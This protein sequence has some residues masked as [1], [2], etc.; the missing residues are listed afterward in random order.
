[1]SPP[2]ADL[3]ARALAHG[4]ACAFGELVR[5]YQS[6]VRGFLRRM[7]RGDWHWADDLAQETFVKAWR[8]LAN[9]RGQASFAAWLYGIAL[10]EY[11]SA[12]RRPREAL[13]L[14]HE[15]GVRFEETCLPVQSDVRLDLEEALKSL[16]ANERAAI[17]LCCQHGLSHEEAA[18]VL[19]C[20]L[21]TVKTHILRGREKLRVKLSNAYRTL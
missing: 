2:D 13:E 10:N 8:K 17:V 7:T 14:D 21:G 1:M 12:A 6:P 11:R 15:D 19:E 20:P 18:G 3:I 5:R 9:Y 4:D 16:E